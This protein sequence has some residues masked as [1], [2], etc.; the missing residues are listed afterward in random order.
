MHLSVTIFRPTCSISVAALAKVQPSAA[1]CNRKAK[2]FVAGKAIKSVTRDRVVIANK[3]GP[4]KDDQN[5][6]SQDNSPAY[7]RQSLET[8]LKNLAVDY[9]DLY[10][11]RCVDNK[12]PIEESV[13]AMAVSAVSCF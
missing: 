11:M 9:I 8:A 10:I 1:S 7:C 12:T 3:W 2:R 13:K 4:M 5:N 6:W